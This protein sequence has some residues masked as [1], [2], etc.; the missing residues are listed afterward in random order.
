MH[1]NELAP[2]NKID[3]NSGENVLK[4]I[5]ILDY[6]KNMGSVDKSDMILSSTETVRKSIKWYKKTFF[7]L[8]DLAVLNASILY[9]QLTLKQNP[10]GEFQI[11]LIKQLLQTYHT[12]QQ[13]NQSGRRPKGANSLLRLSARH[14]PALLPAT[15]AKPNPT[16]RC[17]VCKKKQKR[18]ESRYIC[19][20]CNVSL[21][22][23]PC[24][25]VFHTRKN[26]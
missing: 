20:P 2:S 7:H 14:F 16:K 23:V 8:F 22:V 25:E 9:N 18:K 13:R 3:R 26:Y 24:F 11:N 15:A 4:P 10:V 6:N 19:E 17:I 21:C 12:P 1:T 5:S